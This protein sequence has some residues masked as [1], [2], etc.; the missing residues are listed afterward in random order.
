AIS[1]ETEAMTT[2][3]MAWETLTFDFSNNVSGTPAINFANTYDKV[4][5][6]FNFGTDGAT[7]G[8]KTYYW[9]D[10]MYSSGT[11][12][13]TAPDLPITFEDT[14]T[15]DYDLTDFGGNISQIVV[16]P[17]NSSNLVAE[18]IKDSTAQLW[19]G[20]TA[21][22]AGLVNPVPFA[23]GATSMTVRV[24]SPDANIPVRLKAEDASNGAI[25][26]E[27]EAMTTVAMAW[28]TLTFDFSNNVS[29][30][31]AI[32]FA[33]TYDKVSIFFN[34]GTDGATAGRKTYYWDDVEF[35]SGS[36]GKTAP[37]LPITFE[38]TAT[39][40]YALTDFGGNISQIVVDPTNSS[41]LVTES[42]KDS[43]A[44]LWAGTTAGGSGLL[45]AI[46]F[47]TGKTRMKVRVWSPD[48][49]IPVRLKVE[50]A[51]NA[52]ISV[53]TEAMT[54]MAGMWETL[55]FD[56]S[57][58][59][60][61]TPAINFANTYDKVSIFFNFGTDGA[62]A[63]RK[64]YYWDD[65][66]FIDST[67][68][69]GALSFCN[70]EVFHLGIPGEIASAIF[71]TVEN[72]GANSMKV[73]IESSNA[74][75][76]DFLLVNGGSGA[77]VGPEDFSVP[78]KISRDMTWT[79]TPPANV[80]MNILWSKVSFGGNW[81]LS[82]MDITVPFNSVCVPPAPKP[83][84]PITFED[85]V[86]DYNLADFAGTASQIVVD[87][88][89]PN[90]KVV[91]TLRTDQ[92]DT[93]A[94]T[95]AGDAGLENPIPFTR[96]KT[97]M[98]VRVWSPDANTPVRLKVENS[99]NNAIAS[100]V[101]V[102]TTTAMQWETLTFD[103]SLPVAGSTPVN[104][105]NV[106]DKVIVFFN[107]GTD[108]AT[109]GAK[110]Y[111]WD[112]VEFVDT[113]AFVIRPD[114]PITFEDS[115]LGNYNL[116][117]FEGNASQ[118]VVDPTDPN[119]KVVETLKTD[120]AAT[121]A[122]TVVGAQGL[123]NPI[124]FATNKSRLTVRVWSPDANIPVR[125]KVEN[126]LDG[127]GTFV[128]AETNTTVA[129]Q[130]ET[131]TF[132]FA[133]AV[134]GTLDTTKVFD[135]III[136]FNFGTD[137]A[138]AGAK[139]YFWDDVQFIDSAIVVK[140]PDLPITFED[141]TIFYNLADFGG[142]ASQ[143]VVDPT[144]PSNTV[145]QAI[146]TDM[147]ELWAGTTA[148]GAGL[149]NAIPFALNQTKM[150]VSVWSPDAGTPIRLKV[151]DASNPAISVETEDTTTVAQQWET[152]VFDFSNEAMG[153]SQL[154]TNNTYDK[155]SIFFNFG[156]T[157]AAAGAKTYFFDNIAFGDSSA[158]NVLP[159]LE[160]GFALYP[161]PSRN[162]VTLE[163]EEQ[164]VRPV[165]I[166]IFDTN[167]RLTNEYEL[168][169]QVSRL[170]VSNLNAGVYFVKVRSAERGAYKKLVIVK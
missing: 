69:P 134:G 122:G 117:D 51:A 61:G 72:T 67:S 36:T 7:A 140:K 65:V 10:V 148:G 56:F 37:D 143:I 133:N 15:V 121:F 2:M 162:I 17:T 113:A 59:V 38:D 93:F 66:E 55:E 166:Q 31:P 101:E 165:N 1:V 91:E 153:T 138:T 13:K 114:L 79:G 142:N 159:E 87:P 49:N 34:F 160:N 58:N 26:V 32:N 88:T 94:G 29:G 85:T 77:A 47:A 169:S 8:R 118:I 152:L 53:E 149:E 147:A 52:A 128:E 12:M 135:K 39:V 141:S 102:T 86:I 158:V 105:T 125:L 30:T 45:N 137:G 50:D 74:D 130:W 90:N 68:T 62:T 112:D 155:V 4:S 18:S 107:F 42:I 78:G 20:T 124:P 103:F 115:A 98:R 127:A 145:V 106:Y 19:A 163:F 170:N 161:N 46:P 41:N 23:A 35:V 84:L 108:G 71:L 80:T 82:P 25:S 33:N 70:T 21:G 123:E 97:R 151:E 43:T 60:G 89:D 11:A 44:Q 95:V 3:A 64:T 139:T 119:N 100:E 111:F 14:A 116:L 57:N 76:V 5:I 99:G 6:F 157:G 150:S 96:D 83:D 27:T 120:M 92:A 24:W 168:T 81:Q 132:D 104:P 22:D 126:T 167:G 129:M 9:D 164:P 136:F 154:D 110:T 144:D 156:T 54:T 73:T 109:L 63:G 146:K 28:D 16:D 48:A 131:L 40:D 75:S